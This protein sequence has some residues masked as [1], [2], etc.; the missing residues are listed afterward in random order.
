MP[1]TP[2]HLGPSLGIGFGFEKVLDLPA[3]IVSSLVVDIE[4]FVVLVFN[5]N[6]HPEHGFFHTFLGASVLALLTGIAMYPLRSWSRKVMVIFKLVYK[7]S[8][9]KILWSSFLGVYL[10][11]LID[12]FTHAEMNPFYPIRGNPL[13]GVFTEKQV[14]LFCVASFFIA[15]LLY[16]SLRIRLERKNRG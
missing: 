11:V 10:H 7:S 3:F 1:L 14:V 12:S 9:A 13:F 6:Y 4:P 16:V 2:Y 15:A 5:I 8:F